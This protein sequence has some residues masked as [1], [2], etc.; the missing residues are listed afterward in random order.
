MPS[1]TV[2]QLFGEVRRAV[3]RDTGGRQIPWVS[4]SI[5]GEFSFTGRQ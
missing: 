2:E 3:T 5:P 1:L 4:S